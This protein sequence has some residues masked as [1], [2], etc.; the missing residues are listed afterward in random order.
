MR[1]EFEVFR[2]YSQALNQWVYRK[3]V[4]GVVLLHVP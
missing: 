2:T 3:N 4:C 1:K